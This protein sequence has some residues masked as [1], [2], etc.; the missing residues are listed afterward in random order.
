MTTSG[1]IRLIPFTADWFSRYAAFAETSWG[2][3]CYQASRR[4]VRWLHGAS[5]L[6]AGDGRDF[7]L[8]VR[9]DEVIGCVHNLRL[10]WRIAGETMQVPTP[11]NWM[12]A[13]QHRRG[14]G[15]MLLQ[16]SYAKDRHS[17][18]PV[19][20]GGL[21]D[22]YRKLRFEE[23]T[24]G[25]FRQLLRPARAGARFLLGKAFGTPSLSRVHRRSAL[26]QLPERW[27]DDL[28]L[29]A[30]PSAERQQALFACWERQRPAETAPAWTPELFRWRF[31]H[32]LGP[33]HVVLCDPEGTTVR[34]FCLLSIGLRRGL[35]IGRIVELV[36]EGED[37]RARFTRA[38]AG[39]LAHLGAHVMLAYTTDPA[40]MNGFAACGLSTRKASPAFVYHARKS[41]RFGAVS[42]TASA[43]DFG[44]EAITSWD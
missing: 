32:D 1:E 31:F 39:S 20:D 24:T 4:Y 38:A 43:A 16:A 18:V 29:E 13:P 34:G 23:V 11:H 8:G 19:A 21:T 10:P 28:L 12:V 27:Y 33:R 36:A 41:E 37:E 22:L 35:L 30:R 9:G 15:L 26:E 42:A 3:G 40:H 14:L 5:P 6:A 25:W 17:F 7:I 44:F 2:P